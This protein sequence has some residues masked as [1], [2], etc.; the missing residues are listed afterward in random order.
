ML[1]STQVPH[2]STT[3][4][5]CSVPLQSYQQNDGRNAPHWLQNAVSDCRLSG[6]EPAS[7]LLSLTYWRKEGVM[8]SGTP[9]ASRLRLSTLPSGAGGVVQS[10]WSFPAS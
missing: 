4:V 6:S 5:P 1:P 9:S 3:A 2:E 8:G 10:S 7:S